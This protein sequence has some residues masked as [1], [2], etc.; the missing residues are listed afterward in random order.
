MIRRPMT[1]VTVGKHA[2]ASSRCAS[3]LLLGFLYVRGH[4]GIGPTCRA[5]N[6]SDVNS[7]KKETHEV[8]LFKPAP[9]AVKPDST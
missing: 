4:G 5:F 2:I 6:G 3:Q 1:S 7:N 9:T 8:I